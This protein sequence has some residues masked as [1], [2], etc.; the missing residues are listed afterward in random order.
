MVCLHKLLQV[1][2]KYLDDYLEKNNIVAKLEEIVDWAREKGLKDIISEHR[3]DEDAWGEGKYKHYSYSFTFY[4]KEKRFLF[5]EHYYVTARCEVS[6]A[7]TWRES[8]GDRVDYWTVAVG[9][10]EDSGHSVGN[11]GPEMLEIFKKVFIDLI[12][13]K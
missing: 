8:E 10:G 1:Q 13:S 9:Q 3:I 5:W 6:D 2:K 7:S 4:V 12:E 11:T